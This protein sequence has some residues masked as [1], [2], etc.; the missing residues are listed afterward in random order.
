MA[1]SGADQQ[2]AVL[3]EIRESVA[4][5][6]LNRPDRRNAASWEIVTGLRA[7]IDQ[8]ADAAEARVLVLTGSGRHFC[9]G[10]DLARV[11]SDDPADQEHRTLRGHSLEDDLDR[12][13]QASSVIQSLVDFPKPTIAAVNGACAGAGLSLALAADVQVVSADANIST[14][15]VTAAVS[16]DLGSAWLISRAVGSARARSLLLDPVRLTGA[17]AAEMGLMTEATDDLSSRVDALARKL[18]AQAPRAMMLLKRNLGDATAPRLADYLRAEVP[19]MVETARS[20]DART[21]AA[22]FLDK[23]QPVFTGE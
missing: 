14:A 12:L 17:Q 20:R 6:T 18:A 22:A 11:R 15:F 1:S 3:L 5:I 13:T 8:V 19:R 2:P 16:G 21:A 23:Q 9:V 4:T 7:A 10:A